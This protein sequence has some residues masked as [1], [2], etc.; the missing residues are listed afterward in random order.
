MINL[1]PHPFVKKM[2]ILLYDPL[3]LGSAVERNVRK[4]ST[5]LLKLF[6][7]DDAPFTRTKIEWKLSLDASTI[8]K[9]EE[10]SEQEDLLAEL[11]KGLAERGGDLSG[12][13][14]NKVILHLDKDEVHMWAHETCFF[15]NPNPTAKLRYSYCHACDLKEGVMWADTRNARRKIFREKILE[16]YP[17]AKNVEVLEGIINKWYTALRSISK[18]E[19]EDMSEMVRRCKKAGIIKQYQ[20][21]RSWFNTAR[22]RQNVIDVILEGGVIGPDSPDDILAVGRAYNIGAL[23][24]DGQRIWDCMNVF[25]KKNIIVGRT[26]NIEVFNRLNRGVLEG[27]VNILK[28]NRVTLQEEETEDE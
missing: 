7:L 20:T 11:G 5:D 17:H 26:V 14:D 25:R 9:P 10:Q 1:F 27:E 12:F 21:I 16:F 2:N 15:L 24:T 6:S 8:A 22:H 13:S 4:N 3:F 18:A 28:I 19:D 23:V